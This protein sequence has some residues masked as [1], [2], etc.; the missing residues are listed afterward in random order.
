MLSRTKQVF[1]VAADPAEIAVAL[2][3]LADGADGLR[4]PGAFDGFELAMRGS[5]ANRSR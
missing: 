2:G 3:A 1:D 4:L 5:P